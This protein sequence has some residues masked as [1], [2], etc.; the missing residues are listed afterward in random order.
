MDKINIL[1][2]KGNPLK[3][4]IVFA[5]S[6]NE[7]DKSYVALDY[8]KRVFDPNCTYNNLDIFEIAGEANSLYLANISDSDW[9]I[10]KDYI[11]NQIFS[12]S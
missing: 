12:N 9:N 3:A 1:D 8:K 4:K 2:N 10:V 6:C 11:Q 7:I 5:F